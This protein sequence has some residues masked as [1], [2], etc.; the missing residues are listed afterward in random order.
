MK[1]EMKVLTC[2]CFTMGDV[3]ITDILD[4]ILPQV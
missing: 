3:L 2:E 1:N 4:C